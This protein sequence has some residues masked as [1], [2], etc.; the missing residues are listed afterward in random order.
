MPSA[1]SVLFVL[2]L[3]NLLNYLDRFVLS[4]VL[5]WIERDFALSGFESGLLGSTF[6]L[7]HLAASPLT[8]YLGDR[9][10]R[11]RLIAAGIFLWSLATVGSGLV[12]SYR[13]LLVM[14]AVVGI[15]EASYAVV[16]PAMIADLFSEERRG[17]MLALF[18]LAIPVGTALGYV[19]GGAIGEHYGW[20]AA[21]FVAGA[22]GLVAAAAALVLP[23]PPRGLADE[24]TGE[25]PP[26]TAR[27]AWSR[28]ARSPVWWYD[29]L[30]TAL[31]TFTLGALAFWMPT[32]LIRHHGSRGDVM[33]WQLGGILLL[34]GLTA[35]PLGGALGDRRAR[36]REGGHLEV[37]A[38]ALFAGAPLIA[39][40]PATTRL[41]TTIV[42]SFACLFLLG[43][44]IGPI[45]AVL[46]SCVPARVRATAVA[47]N[48]VVVHLLGDAVSPWLVG[49]VSDSIGLP[50]AIALTAIPVAL[51]GL[52]LARGAQQVN[53]R[54]A[55]LR[56]V[57]S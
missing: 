10:S 15:G 12:S 30:G 53:R 57:R 37:S 49:W 17:R 26:K 14:R 48:L 20:R 34:A 31:V 19:V 4:A 54:H 25:V 35:T 22:P 44:T 18:Y 56:Y 7:L 40:I 13:G 29:T 9:T 1:Y 16:A 32:F 11:K 46:V 50:R 52:L 27:A 51:G 45:N 38:M 3:I 55:G 28:V 39:L 8:G 21:F 41:S 2:A 5:P 36:R 6:M 42:L 33:G 47:L 24:E 23:E 43:L